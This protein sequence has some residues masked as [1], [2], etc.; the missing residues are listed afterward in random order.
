MSTDVKYFDSTM[1]GL[2]GLT[3]SAGTL[4]TALDAILVDGFGQVTLD[5]L[6]VASN[7]ATGTLS[8]GHGFTANGSTGP[9]IRIA[10]ATP[11]GLNGDWRVT[12]TG[13]NTFTFATSGISDQTATGT[14]TAKRAP[15]G[16]TKAYSGTN[17]AV[18]RGSDTG[19]S[20]YYLR[21][22]DSAGGSA[23]V[24]GF[25]TMSDVDTGT[26]RFPASGTDLFMSKANSST[27]RKWF[28]VV[29]QGF[30]WFSSMYFV[31]TYYPGGFV[32]GDLDPYNASDASAVLI[33]G[34]TTAGGNTNVQVLSASTAG[35][36]AQDYTNLGSPVACTRFAHG[37]AGSAMGSAGESAYPSANGGGVLVSAVD[38]W[39]PTVARGLLP[40]AY[41][42]LHTAAQTED[43]YS[44]SIAGLIGRTM[45][46]KPMAS[47]SQQAIFDI[48]GPWR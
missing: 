29:D 20:Q 41:S 31:T 45:L 5:S 9:V 32:F 36:L 19:L 12:I 7:V 40:G 4:I 28:A 2:T 1:S 25:I 11:S 10:G 23:N 44:E 39:D 24:A 16:W 38:C 34:S 21:V 48:T 15:A 13:A 17:K 42:L 33:I 8:T 30:L 37:K 3:N 47:A 14:I 27:A 43:T 35:Y 26:G 18:Y 46:I 6:A 22:D